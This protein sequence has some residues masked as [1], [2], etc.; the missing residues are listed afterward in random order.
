MKKR[1]SIFLGTMILVTNS[2]ANST[3]E[4]GISIGGDVSL[5][6]LGL[7]AKMKIGDSFGIRAGFDKFEKN[8][9]EINVENE[10]D[11]DTK[12]EFDANLQDFF[13]VGDYHPWKGSFRISGGMMINGTTLDGVIT[14][15]AKADNDIEFEFNGHKY[16][17]KDVG[18]VNTKVDWDPIAPYVGIGWD[19]SFDKKEGW[20]FICDLGVAFNGSAKATYS[21]NY[22]EA[23]KENPNDNALEKEAK[24]LS[25][26]SIKKDLDE[27]KLKLQDDLDDYKILPYISLGV[28][29][30][31]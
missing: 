19:T 24:R 18:S 31:F 7:N 21:I 4:K 27:E 30:K 6:G 1:L 22:G 5:Y 26:E 14:P 23:L 2:F 16:S 11:I 8:D 9:I 28:N 3:D 17:T 10:G 12:Y 13:I 25:R 20:G 29:Y 15:K